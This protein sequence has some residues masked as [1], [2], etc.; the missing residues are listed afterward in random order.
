MDDYDSNIF[1]GYDGAA[2]AWVNA[3]TYGADDGAVNAGAGDVLLTS[4]AFG[5]PAPASGSGAGVTPP[6]SGGVDSAS[7]A[8]S[9]LLLAVVR[10]RLLSSTGFDALRMLG[11]AGILL[12]LG[13]G[14]VKVRRGRTAD[15]HVPPG[16]V[17]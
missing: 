9:T 17:R 4:V 1:V 11:L 5:A 7:P 3:L 6:A 16:L 12:A 15:G 13:I 8:P 14:A 2:V 10:S